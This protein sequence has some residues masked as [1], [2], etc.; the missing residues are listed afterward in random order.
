MLRSRKMRPKFTG[1]N[2]SVRKSFQQVCRL[3][4]M[5]LTITAIRKMLYL[6]HC[7]KKTRILTI[8]GHIKLSAR[9]ES[10]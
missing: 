7:S 9:A 8:S 4:T 2:R 1:H 5:V 6:R 10:K 3:T